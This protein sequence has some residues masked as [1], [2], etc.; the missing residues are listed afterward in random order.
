MP[1]TACIPLPG[2]D[3]TCLCASE[4]RRIVDATDL[5]A[6]LFNRRGWLLDFPRDM[7]LVALDTLAPL[8]RQIAAM[9]TGQPSS[10]ASILD[11]AQ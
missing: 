3:L 1:P 5:L 7:A 10:M 4:Q 9:G 8:R 6:T 11:A 2:R